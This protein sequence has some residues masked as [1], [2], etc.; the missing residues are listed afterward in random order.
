[1][2]GELILVESTRDPVFEIPGMPIKVDFTEIPISDESFIFT[3]ERYGLCHTSCIKTVEPKDDGY[4]I[5][6]R[7]STYRLVVK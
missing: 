1:M 5:V 3:C 6:T 2:K 7:N 4:I